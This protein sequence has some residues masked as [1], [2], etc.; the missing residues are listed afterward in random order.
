MRLDFPRPQQV[1]SDWSK[2][3]MLIKFLWLV[4]GLD[5]DMYTVL[6]TETRGR[7]LVG[8]WKKKNTEKRASFLL[9]LDIVVCMRHPGKRQPS[10]T[11][12]GPVWE[13]RENL[14]FDVTLE[15]LNEPNLG[16]LVM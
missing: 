5:I 13:A 8:L 12:R 7:S 14:F 2:E 16:L 4:I 15:S 11:I 10:R 3:T 6:S 1:N 9:L